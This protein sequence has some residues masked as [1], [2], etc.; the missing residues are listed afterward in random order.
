MPDPIKEAYSKEHPTIGAF[1]AHG[2]SGSDPA[3]H[4]EDDINKLFFQ[5]KCTIFQ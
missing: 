5:K 3:N 2:D 4:A 1:A